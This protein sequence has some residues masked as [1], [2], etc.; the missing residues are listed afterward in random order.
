V[1]SGDLDE[2]GGD[3]SPEP[4]AVRL[5]DQSY[6]ALD[7]QRV[8]RM[9][10]L[11]VELELLKRGWIVG[12]F[13]STTMNSAGWDLFATRGTRSVKIRV[14]A[15]RPGVDCFRWSAKADGSVLI[16]LAET[17]DDFVAAVS[18]DP[19]GGYEVFVMPSLVVE[20]T[21]RDE[22]ARWIAGTKPGGGPRKP[23]SMRHIY[24][25]DRDD[26]APAHGFATRWGPCRNAWDL[27]E[28]PQT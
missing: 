6:A 7:T 17:D 16:G 11:V 12:N 25:N 20:H 1:Y 24:I 15:K 4:I 19:N 10:E 13:N 22:N 26:G 9:G 14:K 23:T 3:D 18:F 5:A 8:G 27:L 28:H 2:L 21:L